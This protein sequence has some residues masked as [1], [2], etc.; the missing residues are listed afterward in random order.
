MTVSPAVTVKLE[1][2]GRPCPRSNDAVLDAPLPLA[3]IQQNGAAAR[4][5]EK[6]TVAIVPVLAV[7]RAEVTFVPGVK[8]AVPLIILIA[9]GASAVPLTLARS[10]CEVESALK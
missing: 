6:F 7:Q 10:E 2:E 3:L 4:V 1:V 9:T 8:V 5:A